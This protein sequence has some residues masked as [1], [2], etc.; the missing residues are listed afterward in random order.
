MEFRHRNYRAEE[1][2]HALP[3]SR[4]VTH[5]L[6]SQSSPLHK[7]EVVDDEKIDFYDPLRGPSADAIDVE[8]LQNDASTTGLSSAD[9]IQVQAKEWTSFK[10]LLMQRFSSSKM[11]SIATTS[12]VIVKSGKAYQKSSSMHLQELD[13]PQKF[14]EEGVKVI[15][16]QEY[17][18][19]LHELKDE[20]SRAW[21]A[22]DRV[23]SL[24]LS[25]KVARLLMDTSVLQFYP[26]LFVLATDVMD[27][28]G[29]MVWERIKR[30]AEFAEDGT[31]ICSLSES[32]EA[33]DICL[34]AKETCNNWFCKIG[35]IRELLPRIYLELAMLSCCRFLHDQPINNLNRLVMM[36]RGV[37]DPLASSYCRLYM[38]HCAQKLPT[39]DRGYLIS[40]INDIKILLM[41]MIS[42]KEATHGNSS[43][44]K[45][46][47]VSLM[48]PTIEYIMKCIF[49]DASQRQVGDILVKLGLGRN[50]SELFGK[51]PFVSIILH[52]LL[53]E[54][55]TEVVSSNA[56]EI[57]HLIESCN[58]YSF[59]QCLNYRLLGF[60]LGER[61]SQ[62]DMINAIIDKVIQVVA[63]F[64]CL[65]EYLKVVDSYVD[66][67][68]QNQMDNYLDA[69]LEGV[70]KRAC[71]KE[72][73]ESELGSLQS[74]FSK[75]LAHF[76]NLEDIFA[77]NHF[78]EILDV[79]Y[80]S[81]RNII[82]MQILNIATRNGYIHD[83]ATIQ[84]LLEI[85]QSLHDGIDLFNMKD[86]DNQQ[87]ARLIS[88][89]VQMVDYGIEMEHHLTFLVECRGAFSNIEELKETLVHS[90]NCLAIKAMKEAKKHISFVKSCIAF[91]EVT[92]PSISACPKQLNLY[93]ETAE[94]ALVCGL[95]SHSDGL[96]DSALGC[97]QTLDL[98]DGFQI[99]IDVDGILSLIRKLCSLLVMVPG[100]PEQ[101]AAF[102]PKSILSLVSSQ[103]WITPKMRARI[104]CAIISL[105]ATLSQNKLPYNVDNIEILGND[106]LFFGDSTY[107]QDLVSLSEFVLE[108]LCN[109]IQ[110][111]PSQA[112]RGSMALEAC[113]CIA[114]SFKV[115]PEISPICSKL[116]ETAQ[117]CLSSNNKY[118]QST[119]KLLGERLP[120]F[121]A[122]PSIIIR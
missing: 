37:A 90:C 61:G 60:R 74:I 79:M 91:S 26:T 101:G 65:D 24:K 83:P 49:K 106:L 87:P 7:V 95:V 122:A 107:L 98:M 23:T 84:L 63:Q 35:S 50:E 38:V 67:V 58:D 46:L 103:S 3:R 4:A 104:L 108:E 71:N 53:K 97:L 116:M 89:F 92:I 16:W 41:R 118:L 112:A 54:L 33:S 115:S 43:A 28:L 21:R 78:V 9:A 57:L 66:I 34:D 105:S 96:I 14:A 111:E 45:R 56:T 44:N 8:D 94:V 113:N 76:N 25:I 80:G 114:S 42:E 77:L 99:L 117:L 36:T 100:N 75:L 109:V 69:I 10:R 20:I 72:I 68:L 121:P 11:V 12:D 5:P 15:T 19:R 119:M 47:L 13:D 18:S 86:N 52:H 82:N 1:E 93:L 31:P 40:C 32:F 120:S 29:D 81:S 62:M 59:D 88:R 73:D 27:M 48:E 64:N 22:E 30:K 6:S 2:A 110:Q 55:P 70:S 51:F 85:S 39:C 17:V 102:I